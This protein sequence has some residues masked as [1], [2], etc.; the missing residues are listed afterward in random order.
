MPGILQMFQGEW[1]ALML[2]VYQ[3]RKNLEQTRRELSQALYQHDAAC[4]VICRMMKEKEELQK[5]L[6]LSHDKME[7]FKSQLASQVDQSSKAGG[8]PGFIREEK[9]DEGIY[10]ELVVRMEKLCDNLQEQRKQMKPP[11]EYP[12]NQEFKEAKVAASYPAHDSTKPG[13]LDL[14]IHP[15][16]ENY[17]VSGGKDSHVVLID[18]IQG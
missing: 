13:I 2:E 1:D 12:A 9:Q 16:H 10:K 3:L 6:A 15:I 4:R 17:I 18:N 7:E 8:A 14:D 11:K 5:M